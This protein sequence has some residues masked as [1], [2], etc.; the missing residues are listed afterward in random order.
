M[1][2]SLTI[3]LAKFAIILFTNHLN[4]QTTYQ[5]IAGDSI[6][7]THNEF[8]INV[9]LLNGKKLNMPVMKWFMS[10]YSSAYNYIKV[11]SLSNTISKTGLGVGGLF[12]F[13]GFLVDKRNKPAR[14]DLFTLG[15]IVGSSSLVL[16][17][18]TELF[19]VSAVKSYNEEILLFYMKQNPVTLKME[20]GPGLTINF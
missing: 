9:Y 12:I 13:S 2:T 4:A 14:K 11:A 10:D 20:T 15:A 16:Q 1:K 3:I 6:V 18:I 8:G 7:I 19:K 5:K 17:I